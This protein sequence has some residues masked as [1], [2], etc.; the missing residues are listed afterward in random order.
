MVRV[1]ES[2][3]V[4]PIHAADVRRRLQVAVGRIRPAVIAAG[5]QASNLRR[6]ADQLHTAMAAYVVKYVE[7]AMPI[8]GHEQRQ[9]HELDRVGRRPVRDRVR[10]RNP[11]PGAP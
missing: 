2:F 1:L 6:F 4:V 3:A 5:N 7:R 9:A 11:C 10:E 8:A